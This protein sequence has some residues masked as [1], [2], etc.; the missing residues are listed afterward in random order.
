M[1][2][3][4]GRSGPFCFQ[5]VPEGR[6]GFNGQSLS[7]GLGIDCGASQRGGDGCGGSAGGAK[8]VGQ[9]LAFLSKGF[10]YEGKETGFFKTEFSEARGKS[11]A[12]DSGINVGRRREGFRREREQLFGRPVHLHGDGE[13]A[14]IA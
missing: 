3:F 12:E 8:I 5:A 10:S 6:E 13:Q 1:G 9:R 4:A 2:C 14:V 7:A 11:P